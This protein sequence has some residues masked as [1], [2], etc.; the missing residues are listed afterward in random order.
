M[1]LHYSSD[2]RRATVGYLYSISVDYWV[3]FVTSWEV[4]LDQ[5]EEFGSYFGFESFVE[6]WIEPYYLAFIL[7]PSSC[8]W[9]L[10]FV[11]VEYKILHLVFID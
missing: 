7:P 9:Y 8:F 6:G 11:L 5:L 2:V 10:D 4:F 3:E 1:C